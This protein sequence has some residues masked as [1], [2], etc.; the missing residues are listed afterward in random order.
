MP[1]LP[2]T[3]KRL[4]CANNKLDNLPIIL[5]HVIA[6]LKCCDNNLHD[7][8]LN[9]NHVKY[10]LNIKDNPIWDNVYMP[11]TGPSWLQLYENIKRRSYTRLC[12]RIG[13]WYLEC[14]YNPEYK[15]CRKKLKSEYEELFDNSTE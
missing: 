7:L 13:E 1:E 14:K 12:N 15:Q 11:L 2:N 8:P 10:Y 9:I 4:D 3:L 6:C 5:P